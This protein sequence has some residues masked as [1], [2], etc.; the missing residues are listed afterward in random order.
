MAAKRSTRK[1]GSHRR[2]RPAGAAVVAAP[3]D[4]P[5]LDAL[6]AVD[7]RLPLPPDDRPVAGEAFAVPVDRD[8]IGAAELAATVEAAASAAEPVEADQPAARPVGPRSGPPPRNG[9][10]F[11][12]GRGRGAVSARRYAFRRS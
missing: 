6:N 5:A 9:N 8:R 12:G 11:A 2:A 4:L 3:P 7:G 10:P 1:S